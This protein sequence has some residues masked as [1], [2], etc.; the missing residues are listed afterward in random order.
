MEAQNSKHI[1]FVSLHRELCVKVLRPFFIFALFRFAKSNHILYSLMLCF[2]KILQL[3]AE[4]AYIFF[5]ADSHN[6]LRYEM[7]DFVLFY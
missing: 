1:V 3:F 2:C 7:G 5:K 4:T 6:I